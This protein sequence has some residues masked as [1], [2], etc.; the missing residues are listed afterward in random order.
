MCV[1]AGKWT[2]N[3]DG[4][5]IVQS[6]FLLPNSESIPEGKDLVLGQTLLD[7]E[8]QVFDFPFQ[9]AIAFLNIWNM[10][11]IMCNVSISIN[12]ENFYRPYPKFI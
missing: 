2:V 5:R 6:G 9:G 3:V 11:L 1:L 7:K 10:V 12:F 4:S 8:Q